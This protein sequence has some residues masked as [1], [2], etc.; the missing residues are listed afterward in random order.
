MSDSRKH[1]CYGC[2]VVVHVF[3]VV[4]AAAITLMFKISLQSTILTWIHT[5]ISVCIYMDTYIYL[6]TRI[7]SQHNTHLVLSFKFSIDLT[8]HSIRLYNRMV[9]TTKLDMG[10]VTAIVFTLI[11]FHTSPSNIQ[12][13]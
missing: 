5:C 6:D 11:K 7:E 9:T 13:F 1:F 2:G 3:L 4:T 8:L 10:T 12:F